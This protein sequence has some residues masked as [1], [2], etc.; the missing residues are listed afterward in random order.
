MRSQR[1]RWHGRHRLERWRCA[2]AR[3]LPGYSAGESIRTAP[4]GGQMQPC[5]SQLD[6]L[7]VAS[8]QCRTTV[9]LQP[10]RAC[11]GASHTRRSK[12]IACEEVW[13]DTE[14]FLDR[15]CRNAN[16]EDRDSLLQH[17]MS[18]SKSE[19]DDPSARSACSGFQVCHRTL[20]D[21]Q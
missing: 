16:R 12:V 11:A 21:S 9:R 7:V 18:R 4:T 10:R 17:S 5:Q 3:A 6:L 20:R 14:R 19:H 15:Q 13:D 2:G 8:S 1:A